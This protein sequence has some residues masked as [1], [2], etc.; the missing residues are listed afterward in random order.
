MNETPPP[1]L[2]IPALEPVPHLPTRSVLAR[3]LVSSVSRSLF[4]GRV[5]VAHNGVNPLFKV[6]RR[7]HDEIFVREADSET[8]AG[9]TRRALSATMLSLEPS[10]RQWIMV[11]DPASL[12]LRNLDHLIPSD[13]DGPYPPA[14]VDFYWAAIGQT[15]LAST[16]FWAVRAEHL[17]RVLAL[18]EE[19]EARSPLPGRPVWPALIQTLPLRKKRFEKGEIIAP[20]IGL[21]NW[22][23]ISS[24]AVVTIPEWPTEEQSKFLQSLYF[25]T[26]LGD[27]TGMMLQILDP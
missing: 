15:N 2:V 10:P 6:E 26:Y 3:G 23:S 9:A 4:S 13:S 21:L 18:W 19:A 12:A 27:P 17:S 22:N 5:A 25:G 7:D 14:E 1:L 24:A 20:E 16:G 8:P 11:V